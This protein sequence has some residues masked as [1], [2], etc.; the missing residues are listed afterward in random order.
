MGRDWQGQRE[1][2]SLI[3]QN[4]EL[5]EKEAESVNSEGAA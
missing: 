2:D 4:F 1:G 5:H 3:H